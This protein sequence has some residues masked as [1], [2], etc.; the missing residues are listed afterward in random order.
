MKDLKVNIFSPLRT[1]TACLGLVLFASS[2]NAL[3]AIGITSIDIENDVS[4]LANQRWLQVAE[5]SAYDSLFAAVSFV[6]A[7][8]SNPIFNNGIDHW[9]TPASNA[10]DGS[11]AGTYPQIY[12][13]SNLGESV[14]LTFA[15]P[16]NLAHLTL[17]GRAG[18]A[19]CGFRDVYKVTLNTLAGPSTTFLADASG[20]KA[21][22][23][24]TSPVPE[25]TEFA[26]MLGG[27]GLIGF[28]ARRRRK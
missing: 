8:A 25:P 11:I 4:V 1:M 5:V 15:A 28:L 2:A 27:L 26:M 20:G 9:G 16:V 17:Y 6:Q 22:Q 19:C 21:F 7:T 24:F 13:A 18:D 14:R 3:T 10:I 23:S 12:H